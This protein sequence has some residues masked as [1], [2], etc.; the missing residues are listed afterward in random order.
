MKKML[1]L[2]KPDF[3]MYS[4]GENIVL[5]SPLTYFAPCTLH[6]VDQ[7]TGENIGNNATAY[8]G[9]V[10]EPCVNTLTKWAVIF[11]N[12]GRWFNTVC[13]MYRGAEDNC[14]RIQTHHG[15]W[16]NT[17]CSMYR[18]AAGAEDNCCRIH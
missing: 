14:C 8:W 9:R 10:V 17:V 4:G 2:E 7:L 11:G 15:R 1:V 16:S 6:P 3:V 5:I 18:G 13:S 12:H